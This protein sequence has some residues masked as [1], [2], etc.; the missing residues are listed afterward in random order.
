MIH[1]FFFLF[2]SLL[3][4]VFLFAFVSFPFLSSLFPIGIRRARCPSASWAF[5]RVIGYQLLGFTQKQFVLASKAECMD[6]CLQET[7]FECRS[8]NYD[9]STGDC[10]LSHL[11]RH[12]LQQNLP[13][14]LRSP[15]QPTGSMDYFETNCIQ[16]K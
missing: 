2:P 16:G 3:F 6:R 12:A 10:Y 9:N 7:E 15:L 5:E 4:N 13:G 1:E 14:R 8:V 11:D